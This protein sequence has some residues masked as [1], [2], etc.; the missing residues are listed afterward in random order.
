MQSTKPRAR[1][2]KVWFALI[3][4][5]FFA[6]TQLAIAAPVVIDVQ[7]DAEN[8]TFHAANHSVG[9][10]GLSP[11][12]MWGA[13]A[14]AIAALRPAVIRMFV[15]QFFLTTDSTAGARFDFAALNASLRLIRATGAAPLLSLTFKPPSMFPTIN[16]V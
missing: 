12:P 14:Q 2:S 5:I 13:Q 16:Q 9:Q 10:G 6:L 3:F 1:Q 8:G 7:F 4:L 15:Q 11:K